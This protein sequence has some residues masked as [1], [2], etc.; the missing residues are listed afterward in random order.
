MENAVAQ[1]SAGDL[2][3]VYAWRGGLDQVFQNLI[4]NALKYRSKERV[5]QIEISC[6]SNL[7]HWTFCVSDNGIG[8]DERYAEQIFGVFKRLH[9]QNEY[10]GTGIGLAIVRRVINRLG[11]TVSA[12]SARGH[13]SSFTFTIPKFHG[14]A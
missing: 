1:V 5:P 11:G 10:E 13:G 2:P 14:R 8:F 3:R 7:S 12:E 4:D 9:T 6:D